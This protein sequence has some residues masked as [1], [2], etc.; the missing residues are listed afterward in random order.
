MSAS[1]DQ[2]AKNKQIVEEFFRKLSAG[3]VEGVVSLYSDSCTCWVSG[4]LPFSGTQPRDRLPEMIAGVAQMFPEGL[5]FD[6][7]SM[8]AEDDRVSAEAE[9]FGRHVSGQVYNQLYHYLF[10]I[11]DGRITEIKEYFDTVHAQEVLCSMLAPGF[12]EE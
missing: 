7:R 10:V 1:A 5:S 2:I 9:S 8:T 6:V 4:S 3:D 12:G 11:R